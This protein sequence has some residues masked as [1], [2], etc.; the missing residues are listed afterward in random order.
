MGDRANVVV[1]DDR[2][3][4]AGVFLY[5]HWSGYE[6]PATLKAALDRVPGRWSDSPYL[7]RA[8]FCQM[9]GTGEELMEE[10]GFGISATM[11]D[12]SYPLLIVD[13]FNQVVKEY[14]EEAYRVR[15][16]AGAKELPG[17]PFKDFRGK[18]ESDAGE[19]ETS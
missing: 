19:E 3:Y 13:P 2:D 12:N 17:T 6:L 1:I 4:A 7:A 18:W 9:I 16:L 5:T 8:I 11:G 15:G 10:T 14:A